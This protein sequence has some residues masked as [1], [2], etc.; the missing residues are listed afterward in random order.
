MHCAAAAAAALMDSTDILESMCVCVVYVCACANF[1]MSKFVYKINAFFVG[2]V[3]FVVALTFHRMCVC[4][5]YIHSDFFSTMEQ[6][7]PS[8]A[9]YMHTYLLL[10]MIHIPDHRL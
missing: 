4:T 3:G 8:C 10:Y 5:I 2:F 7:F 9:T 1:S 6:R